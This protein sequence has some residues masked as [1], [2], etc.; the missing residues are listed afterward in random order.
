M[1]KIEGKFAS[2]DVNALTSHLLF[3]SSILAY[4]ILIMLNISIKTSHHQR[5]NQL[6]HQPCHHSQ[7]TTSTPN[8]HNTYKSQ[9]T[10][11]KTK[12]PPKTT[13]T[14]THKPQSP[15]NRNAHYH[16]RHP[17]PNREPKIATPTIQI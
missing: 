2:A 15:Q 17:K 8:H 5:H 10:T 12:S 3:S 14:A 11:L 7:V 16:N 1:C 13:T 9:S 4:N 6:H